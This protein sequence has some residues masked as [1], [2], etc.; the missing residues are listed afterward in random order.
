MATRRLIDRFGERT[1]MRNRSQTD[2]GEPDAIEDAIAAAPLGGSRAEAVQRLQIGITMLAVMITLIALAGII[3]G[4]A[5][6]AE[7]AAVPDAAPTTEPTASPAQRDPLV[8]AGVVPDIPAGDEAQEEGGAPGASGAA[9]DPGAG[10][11]EGE[12]RRVV[13]PDTPPPGSNGGAP[14]PPARKPTGNA[15]SR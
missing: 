7:E 1:P 2:P 10:L 6:R 3:G 5:E 9:A 13:V 8:D 15:G 12:E 11:R 4:Q 14:P